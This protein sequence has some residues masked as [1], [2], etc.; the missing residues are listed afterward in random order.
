M[1]MKT[2]LNELNKS[3]IMN[4]YTYTVHVVYSSLSMQA[5]THLELSIQHQLHALIPGHV[6]NRGTDNISY[7]YTTVA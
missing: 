1:D 3:S 5:A 4:N 7:Q 6:L 2:P